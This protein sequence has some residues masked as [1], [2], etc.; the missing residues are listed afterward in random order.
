MKQ[1]SFITS[2]AFWRRI[3]RN[4]NPKAYPVPD[5]K[6]VQTVSSIPFFVQVSKT[7][8]EA[9]NRADYQEWSVSDRLKYH[10][11]VLQVTG[12]C[13]SF[14]HPFY[15]DMGTTAIVSPWQDGGG[16]RE[17]YDKRA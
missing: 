8:G 7:K 1:A 2:P 3:L 6:R 14:K 11:N 17:F 15:T 4:K 16:L 12:L 5:E 9:S 10:P 13:P